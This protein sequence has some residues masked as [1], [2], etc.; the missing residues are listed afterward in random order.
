M[1]SEVSDMRWAV[2]DSAGKAPATGS[3][4]RARLSL[5]H[6]F[7][8]SK[9]GR[10]LI[11]ISPP[12]LVLSVAILAWD[13]WVTTQDIPKYMVPRPTAVLDRFLND[14]DT[15]RGAF[16]ATLTTAVT[17]YVAAILVGFS[18]A[19]IFASNKV[20]Q[21][22]LYPFAVILQT[23]PIVAIA[24]LIIIWAGP[25]KSAI[26]IITFIITVF[27][28]IANSTVGLMSADHNMVNL[29][30]MNNAS[31]VQSLFKLRIPYA[32]PYVLA[33]LK[34]SAGLSVI[35]AI[36]GEFFAGTGGSGASLGSL[37]TFSAARLHVDMM[38]AAGLCASALGIAF[39]G[40]VSYAG[41]FALRNWHESAV[42]TEN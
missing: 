12:L 20:A 10:L 4:R 27:P 33:G 37:I 35:G 18:V 32:M 16:I 9:P 38:F 1:S 28:I 21:R 3:R 23:T 40:L 11:A 8:A 26:T 17:G 36:V 34:I 7:A 24:P 2:A 25:G 19:M 14:F 13:T 29:F 42:V 22:S 31:P 39:F 5:R 15:L 30:R 41:T 6:R